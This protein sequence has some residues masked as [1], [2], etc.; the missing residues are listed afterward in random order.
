M[1]SRL[2]KVSTSYSMQT[3]N[4]G[5]GSYL[6]FSPS[7]SLIYFSTKIT[8]FWSVNLAE[9]LELNCLLFAETTYGWGLKHSFQWNFWICGKFIV[10]IILGTTFCTVSCCQSYRWFHS[11]ISWFNSCKACC[12]CLE[13]YFKIQVHPQLSTNWDMRVAYPG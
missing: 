12:W 5:R 2:Y 11:N 13:Q 10:C 1:N 9:Y 3:L 4:Y 7:I 8:S 6:G